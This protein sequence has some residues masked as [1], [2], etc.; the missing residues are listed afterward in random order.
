MNLKVQANNAAELMYEI[1]SLY[2]VR[3]LDERLG[4]SQP[5]ERHSPRAI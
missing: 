1:D 5:I 3:E 4:L 2:V